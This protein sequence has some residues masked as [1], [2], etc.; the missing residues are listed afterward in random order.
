[1]RKNR[2]LNHGKSNKLSPTFQ[3]NVID[4]ANISLLFTL[5][6]ALFY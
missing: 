5:R 1:M 4:I 6:T 3:K 2:I